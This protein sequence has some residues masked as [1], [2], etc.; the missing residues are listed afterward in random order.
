MF[1]ARYEM[2]THNSGPC[3]LC[4]G[5]EQLVAGLFPRRQA[6]ERDIFDVKVS[7]GQSCLPALRFTLVSNILPM[8]HTHLHLLAARNR[9]IKR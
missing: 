9:R 2:N 5:S 7:L 6:S 4:H 1:T 3:R 8:F